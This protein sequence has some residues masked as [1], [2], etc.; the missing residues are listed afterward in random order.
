MP[1]ASGVEIR[2]AFLIC[3]LQPLYAV[4]LGHYFCPEFVGHVTD[5]N[6]LVD[7]GKLM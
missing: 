3:Y 1:S 5:Q 6:T 7:E 4:E 2:I